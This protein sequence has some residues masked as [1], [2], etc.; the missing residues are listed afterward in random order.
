MFSSVMKQEIW[1]LIRELSLL[2]KLMPTKEF[3]D[4]SSFVFCRSVI[5]N[6]ADASLHSKEEKNIGEISGAIN[7]VLFKICESVVALFDYDY[8]FPIDQSKSTGLAELSS[9]VD[10]TKLKNGIGNYINDRLSF[11]DELS[12][13][14]LTQQFSPDKNFKWRFT[15]QRTI[16]MRIVLVNSFLIRPAW[17]TANRME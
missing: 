2:I 17:L 15:E 10:S 11:S 9:I 7:K 5:W 4:L 6:S 12:Y 3:K 1:N 13:L 14:L 16:G 8:T